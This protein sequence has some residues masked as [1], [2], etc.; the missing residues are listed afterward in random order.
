MNKYNIIMEQNKGG[1]RSRFSQVSNDGQ[2]TVSDLLVEQYA[3]ILYRFALVRVQNPTIAEDLVQETF[4][5]A[6]K[7]QNS[8][9]SQSSHQTWL[10]GILKHK[11]IDHF[12]Y[13]NKTISIEETI[14]SDFKTEDYSAGNRASKIPIREWD[15]SPERIVE[16]IALREALQKCL[17][18]LPE[19]ARQLFLMRE[20]DEVESAEL[21]KIFGITATNLWVTLY[22][23]RKQLKNCLEKNWFKQEEL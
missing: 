7:S 5:A 6:L 16:D 2:N 19:K 12:R 8:F 10:T 11:I 23:I 3:D 4:V 15:V 14:L 17:D 13:Q 21:C 22:R 1:E 18:H 9:C 20:A